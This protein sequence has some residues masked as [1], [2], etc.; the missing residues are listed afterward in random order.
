MTETHDLILY[1][2][3]RVTTDWTCP[4]KRF[5]QYEYKGKGIVPDST[6]LE[7][8][9]GTTLHDGLAAIATMHLSGSVDINL[10]ADTARQQMFNSLMETATDGD[11]INFA[12]E[13]AALVEGLLRGFYKHAWTRL[14]SAYPD[15]LYIEKEMTFN[16]NGL[17]FMARPDLVLSNGEGWYIEFKSTSSKKE[18][19]VNSWA[20]AVQLHSTCRA[21]EQTTG[22]K[23]LGVIVQGLYKGYESYG[24]QNSP[25]CYAFKRDGNPPFTQGEIRYDYKA[26]FKRVPTWELPG[27]TAAWVDSMPEDIL[28][29]QFP[30]TP[31]IFIKDHLV[32][33]FFAQRAAREQEIKMA[34]QFLE[35]AD[36]E[37][38]ENILNVA[39]PQRFDQCIPYFGRPCSYLRLCHG[40]VDDPLLDGF[41]YRQPHHD[42][43]IVQDQDV[44]SASADA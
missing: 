5:W 19:W 40:G 20:T 17:T 26:G 24:R 14:I 25:M 3:S 13:Q 15:I 1:D 44:D 2:R 33:A 28:G 32:D 18:G 35:Q 42:L 34:T 8:F 16:H 30:Q 39:F 6:S 7:L 22:S 37:A 38:T 21:I 41:T 11:E 9:M 12:H 29:D 23:P 10:I 36:A 4:R 43:E 27:G 31:P